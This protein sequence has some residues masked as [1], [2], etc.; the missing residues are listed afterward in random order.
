[1]VLIVVCN[2]ITLASHVPGIPFCPCCPF[3]PG[4]PLSPGDPFSP[5]VKKVKFIQVA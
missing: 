1:M 4:D 2:K 3:S 5:S